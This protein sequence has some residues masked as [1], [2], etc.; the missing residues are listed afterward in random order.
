MFWI[1]SNPTELLGGLSHGELAP[2]LL[3]SPSIVPNV[4]ALVGDDDRFTRHA[5]SA[6][7]V[8]T[9]ATGRVKSDDDDD[10]VLYFFLISSLYFLKGADL[11]FESY[12]VLA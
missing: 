8:P 11:C 12:F 7:R 9:I 6:K 3:I 5:K 1:G 10:D 4:R 2:A